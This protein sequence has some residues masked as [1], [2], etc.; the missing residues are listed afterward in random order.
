MFFIFL[1]FYTHDITDKIPH[2]NSI[3]RYKMTVIFSQSRFWS[4]FKRQKKTQGL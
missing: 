1:A 3:A 2:N 4:S